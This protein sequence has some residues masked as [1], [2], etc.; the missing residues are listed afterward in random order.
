MR[1]P[2]IF[3]GDWDPRKHGNGMLLAEYARLKC[4]VYFGVLEDGLRGKWKDV[5]FK[6][7]H[8]TCVKQIQKQEIGWKLSILSLNFST[9]IWDDILEKL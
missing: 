5:K 4:L 2:V 3:I 7:T 6:R 9:V 1:K 8:L